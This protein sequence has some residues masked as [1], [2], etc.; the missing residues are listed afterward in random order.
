MKTK[1]SFF[2]PALLLL[3]FLYSTTATHIASSQHI[4]EPPQV[5]ATETFNLTEDMEVGLE[6]EARSPAAAWIRKGAEAPAL[7]ISIDGKYNQ[8]LLLWAGVEFFNYRVMLGRLS[9]G[10]HTLSVALNPARSAARAL[11]AEVKSLRPIPLGAKGETGGLDEEQLA[12]A[13][14]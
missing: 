13:H 12:L 4:A 2:R 9:R 7:L 1:L 10:E 8:D 14:S 6:I 11:S 3:T 5:L